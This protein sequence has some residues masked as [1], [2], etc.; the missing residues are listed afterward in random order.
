MSREPS[1]H[2]RPEGSSSCPKRFLLPTPSTSCAPR[3]RMG[4]S[5]SLSSCP[6]DCLEPLSFEPI[7]KLERHGGRSLQHHESPISV[8]DALCGVPPLPAGT[9]FWD[10]LLG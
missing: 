1:P 5:S 8:G 3:G 7:P 4:C 9:R 2:S 10:R 6:M